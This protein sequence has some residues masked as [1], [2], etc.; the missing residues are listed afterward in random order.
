MGAVLHVE[1]VARLGERHRRA[2]R[3]ATKPS[4]WGSETTGRNRKPGPRRSV[5]SVG[6]PAKER[7]PGVARG[8]EPL[9]ATFAGSCGW[10]CRRAVGSGL[11]PPVCAP[12][13]FGVRCPTTS[14]S[15]RRG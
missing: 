9:P 11:A 13:G 2:T 1:T 12:D 15:P 8:H 5:R 3:R 4:R 6:D 10:R 14:P 7:Q